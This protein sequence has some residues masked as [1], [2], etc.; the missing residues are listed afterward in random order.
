MQLAVSSAPMTFLAD[1][2]TR[3]DSGQ[4]SG[5]DGPAAP[6][7]PTTTCDLFSECLGGVCVLAPGATLCP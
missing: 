5:S 1:A 3:S 7:S 4:P 6:A 2:R